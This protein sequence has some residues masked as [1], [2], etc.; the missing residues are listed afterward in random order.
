MLRHPSNSLCF[1]RFFFPKPSASSG[2]IHLR[3]CAAY[4]SQNRQRNLKGY[5]YDTKY[6]KVIACYCRCVSQKKLHSLHSF[7]VLLSIGLEFELQG[8][9][10]SGLQRTSLPFYEHYLMNTFML[11]YRLGAERKGRWRTLF[12]RRGRDLDGYFHSYL[13]RFALSGVL[14]GVLVRNAPTMLAKRM[15]FQWK[16][17]KLLPLARTCAKI[18]WGF[19]HFID[20][21]TLHEV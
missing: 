17:D 14:S 19:R 12:I 6:Y 11:F 1:P 7:T 3:G 4:I 15:P 5:T 10:V 18:L 13:V 2:Q 9:R 8:R 20:R 21:T 16:R